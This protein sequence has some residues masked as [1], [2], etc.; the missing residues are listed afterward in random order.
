MQEIELEFK[1][2][3]V[4]KIGNRDNP[5]SMNQSVQFVKHGYI[6]GNNIKIGEPLWLDYFNTSCIRSIHEYQEGDT[7]EEIIEKVPQ[8]SDLVLPKYLKKGD[9]ILGTMN[10]VYLLTEYD[11]ELKEELGFRQFDGGFGW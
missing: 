6:P 9:V 2:Y 5:E 7:Y 11:S 4:K 1:K 10:S 8:A 3:T